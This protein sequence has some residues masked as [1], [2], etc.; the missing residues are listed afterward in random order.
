M[1]FKSKVKGIG[2][3]KEV[4]EELMTKK[5]NKDKKTLFKKKK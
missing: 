1:K 3:S 4:S 5:S 2:P